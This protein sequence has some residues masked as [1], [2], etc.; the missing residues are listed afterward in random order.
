MELLY[1]SAEH[2]WGHS[3]L[4]SAYLKGHGQCHHFFSSHHLVVSDS[5]EFL[6]GNVVLLPSTPRWSSPTT[7]F[8]HLGGWQPEG[9]G[10]PAGYF[11]NL[12]IIAVL[13]LGVVNRP[14]FPAPVRYPFILLHIGLNPLGGEAWVGISPSP[15]FLFLSSLG[16]VVARCGCGRWR[17]RGSRSINLL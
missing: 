16:R 5:L 13:V 12:G 11:F 10:L 1:C 3:R 15:R 8:F 9:C 7:I 14:K 6:C 17:S 2:P 4:D